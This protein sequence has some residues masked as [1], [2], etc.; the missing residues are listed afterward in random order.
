MILT[1]SI[2]IACNKKA[3]E[4]EDLSRHQKVYVVQAGQNPYAKILQITDSIQTILINGGIG[5]N[6]PAG[7][8]ITLQFDFFEDSVASYNEKNFTNY[9]VVPRESFELVGQTAVIKRGSYYSSSM[10]IKL[11]TLGSI[12]PGESYLLPVGIS[13]SGK[14][15]AI[16]DNLRIAYLLITGSYPLGKEPPIKVFDLAG[17]SIICILSYQNVIIYIENNGLLSTHE[18]DGLAN[19]YGTTNIFPNGGWNIFDKVIGANGRVVTRW[20]GSGVLW[21]YPFDVASRSMGF[22]GVVRGEHFNDYEIIS[23]SKQYNALLCKKS[24]GELDL[25]QRSQTMW[26]IRTPLGNEFQKYRVIEAYLDGFLAID[27]AGDLFFYP[28]K[29]DLSLGEMQHVGSGWNKYNTLMSKDHNLMAMDYAGILWQFN[30]NLAGF[31]EI[32]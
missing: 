23:Y 19:C 29:N 28:I 26:D 32:K 1:L 12:E 27:G 10:E 17:K 2:L 15:V 11:K 6:V 25:I 18:W 20:A 22:D 21:E 7:N 30:F 31:W 4:V 13:T 16:N 8:D 3:I 24:S 9:K 14:G 5:G